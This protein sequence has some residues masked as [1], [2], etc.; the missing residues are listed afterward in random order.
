M[1]IKPYPEQILVSKISGVKILVS[2]ILASE[3]PVISSV[4]SDT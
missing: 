2:K 3:Y 1:S 4:A